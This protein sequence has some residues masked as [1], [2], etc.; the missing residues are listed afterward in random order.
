MRSSDPESTKTAESDLLSHHIQQAYC[1]NRPQYRQSRKLTAVKAYSVANES[2]HLLVF[3]VPQ[4][5]LTRELRNEL[6][7]YGTVQ[8]VQNVTE[9]LKK[10]GSVKIE[11]FTDVFHVKFEKLERARRAKKLLDA[12]NFYGGIL[13]VSYAPERET[14]T[15]LREKLFKRRK[16]VEFRLRVNTPKRD[17]KATD[18]DG[19]SA[20]SSGV[21]PN[22]RFKSTNF[23]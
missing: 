5:D 23:P 14:V 13:H 21:V 6:S 7:R 18:P 3:G 12:R 19:S 4:I 20:S 16:E 9:A 1:K 8:Q 11:A 17:H 10:T 22:K 15:E 2:R